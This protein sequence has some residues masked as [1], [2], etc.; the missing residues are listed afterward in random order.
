MAMASR[1]DLARLRHARLLAEARQGIVFPE[2]GDHRTALAPFT[3]QSGRNVRDVLRH[4]KT[5][6]LQ[7]GQMFGCGARLGVANLGHPPDPVT[8]LDESPLDRIDATPD[9]SAVVHGAVLDVGV[10]ST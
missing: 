3:H 7:L 8:Q 9:V 1:L 6:M 4:A 2:E 10:D 5:L